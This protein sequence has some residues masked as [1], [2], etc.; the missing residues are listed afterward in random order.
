MP[1]PKRNIERRC[2]VSWRKQDIRL[3]K[4]DTD[5]SERVRSAKTA[6]KLNFIE[7]IGFKVDFI[8]IFF[9]PIDY[10]PKNPITLQNPEY[11]SEYSRKYLRCF[12]NYYFH[13]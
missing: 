8:S 12:D 10:M 2:P 13:K 9:S 11:Y 6:R 5:V 3:I 4:T 7:T 1:A